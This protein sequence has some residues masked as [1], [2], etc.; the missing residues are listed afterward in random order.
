IDIDD[1]DENETEIK[2]RF[3]GKVYNDK[4]RNALLD[5][6][7]SG[8]SG[9]NI[10][11]RQSEELIDS[12]ITSNSGEYSFE[13]L[14]LGDYSIIQTDLPTWVSTTPNFVTKNIE[15]GQDIEI[16]FGDA[17]RI[18]DEP[19]TSSMN[20]EVYYDLDADKNRDKDEPGIEGVSISISNEKGI[21]ATQ[22]TDKYG[23]CTFKNLA[24]GNYVIIET[25][26][27]GHFST[28][29]NKVKIKIDV[30]KNIEYKVLF[31]DTE[32]ITIKG[33][34]FND[35]D[36][37]GIKSIDEIG[38]PEN[39]I[40]ITYNGESSTEL[41]KENGS[42]SY[43]SGIP[44]NCTVSS[45]LPLNMFR[46]TPGT[47]FLGNLTYGNLVMVDFGYSAINNSFGVVYGTVYND[48]NHSGERE[49]ENGIPEV[50]LHL[51]N[52]TTLINTTFTNYQGQYTFRIENDGHYN[53]IEEDPSGYVSTTPNNVTLLLS[54][55]SASIQDFGDFYGTKITGKVF[56]D[57][58]VNGLWGRITDTGLENITISINDEVYM[59]DTSGNF[60]LYVSGT[61][62]YDIIETDPTGLVSTNAIP[63][64]PNV[65][66]IDANTLRIKINKTGYTIKDN[67][68]GDVNA[69][70]VTTVF[71]K[72]IWD[73]NQDGVI[74]V[75]EP[76]IPGANVSIYYIIDEIM[77][78]GLQ[79]T[80]GKDGEWLL[81]ALPGEFFI[82]ETNVE[83]YI[84]TNLV[85]YS[86]EIS[87]IDND[88]AKLT[89]TIP[90]ENYT[91]SFLD[92]LS[93]K[94][95]LIQGYIFDDSNENG[96][97]DYGE[98]GISGLNITLTL[99]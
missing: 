94:T 14:Q 72:V 63:G 25:D 76:G 43:M 71:G 55:G 98:T 30:K 39:N 89:E 7:E 65:T 67:L 22:K 37:N 83:D 66:K 96:Q 4:N 9:V 99:E 15:L 24:T 6:G 95:A 19:D 32:I 23:K 29:P 33:Y 58:D 35:T 47:V 93:E 21:I 59:T 3:F 1:P 34:A 12:Y 86:I 50:I 88:N 77:H 42:Y 54:N 26:L 80:T 78:P 90:G 62:S 20:V 74:D 40:K 56:N 27:D 2:T 73:L 41:T 8:L 70:E 31:G 82:N 85:P 36:G 44:G 13:L 49:E 51:Y 38:I 28:T 53:I 10:Q 79:M 87:K 11:L 48:T 46:T 81:Y 64:Y 61:G 69:S 16:N 18:P 92:A 91:L 97:F 52:G 60:T 45:E 57:L 84:S 75:G 5:S 17:V 68:F